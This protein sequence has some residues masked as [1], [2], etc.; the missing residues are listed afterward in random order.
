MAPSPERATP[1]YI[2]TLA[3]FAAGA[4]LIAIGEIG[5]IAVHTFDPAMRLAW[6]QPEK[7]FAAKQLIPFNVAIR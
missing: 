3:E 1:D 2:N 6:Q 7:S 4:D 5:G